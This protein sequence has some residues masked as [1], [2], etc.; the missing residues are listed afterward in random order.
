MRPIPDV[1]R[2]AVLAQ[3]KGGSRMEAS[4]SS[5]TRNCVSCGRSISWDANVCPYCGHD[6]RMQSF[7]PTNAAPQMSDGMKILLYIVS[8]LFSIVG[9]IIGVYYM[10][11]NEPEYKEVGKIC[12]VLGLVGIVVSILCNI[13]FLA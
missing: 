8:F 3:E 7:A 9:I 2:T 13:A 6:Y 11:K 4:G 1:D 5:A 10:T 12:L